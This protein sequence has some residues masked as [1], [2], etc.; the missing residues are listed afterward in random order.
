[1]KHKVIIVTGASSGI[2]KAIAE[3]YAQAQA[4]VVLAARSREL[5]EDLA[6]SL[7]TLYGV[8]VL[9]CETDVSKE[10]DCKKLVE[11]TIETF[12]KLDILVNN[13]GI[14]MR[15]PFEDTELFVI[16]QIMDVNFFGAV[17]CVKY[18]LP[19]LKETKGVIVNISSI[20]GYRGLTGRTGYSAS[21]YALNGFAEALRTEIKPF[22]IHVLQVCPNFTTSNIRKSAL[23]K[24]GKAQ[25]DSPR[26]EHSMM[27]AEKVA[28]YVYK[29]VVYKR[30]QIILTFSGNFIVWLNRWAPKLLDWYIYRAAINEPN[31]PFR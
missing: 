6:L 30:R 25:G 5:L 2:G 16:R 17:Y 13:A 12:G 11:K 19:Y 29:G 3:R 26:D 27:S 10:E 23:T 28:E 4:T 21:K 1:M 14:S 20:A 22:G 31:S 18:S 7:R 9:V 24:D 15:A 8:K